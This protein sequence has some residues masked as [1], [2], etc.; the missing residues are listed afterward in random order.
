[1]VRELSW[2]IKWCSLRAGFRERY[3]VWPSAVQH[4]FQV[5]LQCLVMQNWL[6]AIVVVYS[7]LQPSRNCV[8]MQLRTCAGHGFC[9]ADFNLIYEAKDKNNLNLNKRLLG[10]FRKILD[11]CELIEIP[12]QNRRFN[13]SNSRTGAKELPPLVVLAT[14][15]NLKPWWPSAA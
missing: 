4:G 15:S 7:L 1:M 14:L 6:L 11:D 3:S 13:R 5:F 2:G 12:M 8:Q 10:S 9:T